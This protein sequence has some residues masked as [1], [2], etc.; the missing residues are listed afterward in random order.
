MPSFLTLVYSRHETHK[1][2]EV[3]SKLS[4]AKVQ[5]TYEKNIKGFPV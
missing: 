1:S 2:L 3:Y 5:E 4:L